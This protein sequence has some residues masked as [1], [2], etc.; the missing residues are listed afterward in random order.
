MRNLYRPER[1]TTL[2]SVSR[3]PPAVI[4]STTAPVQVTLYYMH[5]AV[6]GTL[7]ATASLREAAFDIT[8]LPDDVK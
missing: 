6:Q 5:R 8:K 7:G 3:L 4:L 2:L 1:M